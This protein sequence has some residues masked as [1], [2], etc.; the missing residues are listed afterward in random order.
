MMFVYN[1]LCFGF[2]DEYKWSG[3]GQSRKFYKTT[4]GQREGG[5]CVYGFS[6][7]EILV[8]E[9]PIFLSVFK[10]LSHEML[11]KL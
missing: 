3:H 8:N 9:G 1:V 2:Q 7:L 6:S 11:T 5:S 4:C 10:Q